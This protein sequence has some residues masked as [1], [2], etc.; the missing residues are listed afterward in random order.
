MGK[1]GSMC[2]R[3]GWICMEGQLGML[4]DWWKRDNAHSA[5]KTEADNVSG[6]GVNAKLLH[7]H[8]NANGHHCI[9]QA[10]DGG[11]GK[12]AHRRKFSLVYFTS[13]G[14]TEVPLLPPLHPLRVTI[15]RCPFDL[16]LPTPLEVDE[17]IHQQKGAGHVGDAGLWTATVAA[18]VTTWNVPERERGRQGHKGSK[19]ERRGRKANKRVWE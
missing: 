1:P 7:Q 6:R 10:R 19:E 4:T 5:A 9:T 12:E 17:L 14:A 13:Q 2:M 15:A 8:G 18:R 16:S 11:G 3:W